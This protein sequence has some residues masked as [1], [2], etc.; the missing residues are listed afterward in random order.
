[1]DKGFKSI[2]IQKVYAYDN[3]LTNE[4]NVQWVYLI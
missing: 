4:T 1:M 3:G 2:K